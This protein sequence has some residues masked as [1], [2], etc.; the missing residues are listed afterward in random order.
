MEA[1][2][3]CCKQEFLGVTEKRKVLQD[4]RYPGLELNL[5]AL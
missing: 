5:M 2:V 4:I 3:A 1:V